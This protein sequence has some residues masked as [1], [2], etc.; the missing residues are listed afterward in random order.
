MAE[1]FTNAILGT[2][3]RGA[4]AGLDLKELNA[5]AVRVMGEV[6]VDIFE[7]EPR[8]ID[9]ALPP[10]DETPALVIT[11][12]S[13]ASESCPDLPAETA[14]HNVEFDDPPSLA[15][16]AGALTEDHAISYYHKVRDQIAAFVENELPGLIE[17]LVTDIKDQGGKNAA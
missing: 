2:T 11:M 12:C 5:L 4:S 15:A 17:T 13:Q 1:G 3:V 16:Q 10:E 7:H 8:T 9:F 14:C 6:G